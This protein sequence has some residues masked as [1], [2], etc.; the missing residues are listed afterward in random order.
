MTQIQEQYQRKLRSPGGSDGGSSLYVLHSNCWLHTNALLSKEINQQWTW[1]GVSLGLEDGLALLVLLHAFE[2]DVEEV[3]GVQRASL[4]LGVELGA[5]DWSRLMNHT[6]RR[7]GRFYPGEKKS[8]RKLTFVAAIVQV[9]EVWLPVAGQGGSIHSIS[10][11]LASNVA[12]SGGQVQGRNVVGTVAVLQLDGL[13]ANSEGKQLVSQADPHNWD[14]RRLHQLAEV[15]HSLL[16]V[17]GVTR[18]VGDEDSIE[19]VGHLVNRVVVREDGDAGSTADQAAKDVLLDTAVDDSNVALRVGR[20]HVERS[21][22]ADLAD[23]VDLL[24]IGERLIL[25]GIV[26]F[27]NGDAGQRRTLFTQIGYNGTGVD[28]RDGR[29]TLTGTPLAKT[30]DSSPVAVLL[31]DIR[32]DNTSGLNIGRLEVLEQPIGVL[33]GRGNAI[34]ANQGLGEDQDLATVGRIR[35]RFGVPNQGGGEDSFTRDVHFGSEGLA[36]ED[37]AISDRKS[38]PVTANRDT[39]LG[40]LLNF[41]VNRGHKPSLKVGRL[42]R[43][44]GAGP[45]G[46]DLGQSSKHGGCGRRR[47]RVW[48]TMTQFT[49]AFQR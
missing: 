2:V 41:A 19:V 14:L 23:K 21:L 20:A 6:C 10:M 8:S 31:R 42:H 15:E 22:G 1:A 48:S 47:V 12:A 4:G 35:E 34:V 29:H 32:D 9:H 26:L 5:E 3:R 38:R 36:M 27:T 37:R 24:R 17:G 25:V 33:F 46:S 16:A 45:G 43:G 28:A 13:G 11:V 44:Q 18:S 39:P 30:L 49:E 7:L 40:R